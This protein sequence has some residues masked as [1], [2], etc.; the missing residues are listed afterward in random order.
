MLF[1]SPR[2]KGVATAVSKHAGFH[3]QAHTRAHARKGAETE[4]KRFIPFDTH[5]T[6]FG[7]F[8]P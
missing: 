5:S 3:L 7:P 1:Y 2:C 8:E 6:H 4:I